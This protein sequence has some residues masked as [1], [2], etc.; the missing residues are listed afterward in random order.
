MPC[1]GQKRAAL[2]PTGSR[3]RL[4]ALGQA[5]PRPSAATG[6]VEVHL[7]YLAN[8]AIRVRGAGTRRIYDFSSTDP[9]QRVDPQDAD[10]LLRT[11]LF[12]TA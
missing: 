7:V 3:L 1:C 4:G 6:P 2:R 5:P 10:A 12:R 11:G 8:S 9:V